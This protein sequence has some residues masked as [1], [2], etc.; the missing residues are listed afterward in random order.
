MT[1]A[2]QIMH[3]VSSYSFTMVMFFNLNAHL[4]WVYTVIYESNTSWNYQLNC[5]L[6]QPGCRNSDLFRIHEMGEKKLQNWKY[7]TYEWGNWIH[8][9]FSGHR[10]NP[11]IS[12]T[13]VNSAIFFTGNGRVLNLWCSIFD[14]RSYFNLN[15]DGVWQKQW[16]EKPRFIT[17]VFFFCLLPTANCL[18]S[19]QTSTSIFPPFAL[20]I[21]SSLTELGAAA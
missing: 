20:D 7:R 1:F 17:R 12:R 11:G 8:I 9:I 18:L 2:W 16:K 3:I 13:A 19:Y 15:L 21:T 4:R 6:I 10:V 14:L 5:W